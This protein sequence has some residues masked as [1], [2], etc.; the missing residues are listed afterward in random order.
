MQVKDFWRKSVV[1]VQYGDY[2][3]TVC[4]IETIGEES[5]NG[6]FASLRKVFDIERKI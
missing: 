2:T 4:Y 3:K 6:D 1:F 5:V